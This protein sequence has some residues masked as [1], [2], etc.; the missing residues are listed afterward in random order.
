MGEIKMKKRL[1]LGMGLVTL[2]VTAGCSQQAIESPTNKKE[3]KTEQTKVQE[4]QISTSETSQNLAGIA[5]IEEIVEL[6]QKEYP[7]T[8]ITSLELERS[9]T[10]FIYQV[11]GVDNDKEYEL[12]IKAETKEIIKNKEEKLEQDERKGVKRKSDSLDLNEIL[13][14]EEVTAIAQNEVATEEAIEW[15]LDKTLNVTYWEITFKQGSHETKVKVD[16][17]SGEVLE[18]EQDD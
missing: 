5:T 18:T 2:L 15:D 4:T 9:R 6:F 17:K 1:L 11:E 7:D 3:N 12:K 13:S 14:L 16:A 8:D 10:E